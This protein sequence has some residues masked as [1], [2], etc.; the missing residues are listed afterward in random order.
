MVV[1]THSF[2]V[3]SFLYSIVPSDLLLRII[4]I[5]RNRGNQS[6]LL[7]AKSSGSGCSSSVFKITKGL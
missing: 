7:R 5:S 1:E 6:T 2:E 3:L 4:V